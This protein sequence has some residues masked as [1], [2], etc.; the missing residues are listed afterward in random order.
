MALHANRA[1]ENPQSSMISPEAQQYLAAFMR[2]IGVSII[3]GSVTF[4]IS[5]GDIKKVEA[6]TFHGVHLQ[7]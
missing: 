5:N 2:A 1:P 6:K 4:H 7:S 3:D